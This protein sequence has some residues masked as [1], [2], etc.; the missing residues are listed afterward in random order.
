MVNTLY[1][2]FFP[3]LQL[4][5]KS[6]NFL[7]TKKSL[8]QRNAASMR[9]KCNWYLSLQHSSLE[10]SCFRGTSSRNKRGKIKIYNPAAGSAAMEEAASSGS[11]RWKLWRLVRSVPSYLC[12]LGVALNV[13]KELGLF[14]Q[15]NFPARERVTVLRNLIWVDATA[16]P[17]VPLAIAVD[18]PAQH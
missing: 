6:H 18:S 14:N 17:L 9:V 1:F 13:C 7:L 10:H 16:E 11:P 12:K 5:I 8:Y 15:K 3:P 2:C 4:S